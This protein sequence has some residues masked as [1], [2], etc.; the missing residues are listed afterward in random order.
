MHVILLRSRRQTTMLSG[1]DLKDAVW[2]ETQEEMFK[3][4]NLDPDEDDARDEQTGD[5]LPDDPEHPTIACRSVL[6]KSC[7]DQRPQASNRGI[8]ARERQQDHDRASDGD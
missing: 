2:L 5:Q 7:V 8:A 4:L 3:R 1:T 6:R